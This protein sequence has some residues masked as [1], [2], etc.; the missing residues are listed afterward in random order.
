MN[1]MVPT[2]SLLVGAALAVLGAS[3]SAQVTVK[4]NKHFR[5]AGG[6]KQATLD[7][8]TGTY[9]RGPAVNNRGGTTIADFTNIDAFDG[10]GFGWLVTETGGGVCKW[11]SSGS[12]GTQP[13]QTP[14]N[15]SDMVSDVVFFY[16][17]TALDTLSGGIG[18]SASLE[19]YEGYTVTG[20]RPTTFVVSIGMSQMPANTVDGDPTVITGAGCW[21]LRI[22]FQPMIT[23]FQDQTF[24]GYSWQ[25]D[26][27]GTVSGLA[28]T[29]PFLS[30]IVS[31]SGLNI[32]TKG[33]AG[34]IGGPI[35]AGEDGQG[36]IDVI[37]QFCTAP[38]TAAS[39]SFGTTATPWAPTTRVSVNMRI[40]EAIDAATTNLNYNAT[41]TPNGDTLS[42]NKAT[43]GA[44]WTLTITRSPVTV[45]GAFVV[46]VKRGRFPG[47]GGNPTPPVTG[48]VL[49]AGAPLTSLPSTPHNGTTGSV[50]Q[51][52]PLNFNFCGLHFAAQARTTGG[53]IK[54]SSG[55]EGT[56][57]TF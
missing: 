40:N 41:L 15:N 32:L 29:F 20:G 25:F 44:R 30:C 55:V 2:K 33:T 42:A 5:R 17:S 23:T 9:T 16:C 22:E 11:F 51:D 46:N 36:M 54:L 48:R 27:E 56:V 18:G 1:M 57:G 3:A 14:A 8:G 4:T 34:G 38:V 21:G 39:F 49:I 45:A 7:L 35:G 24:H 28:K 26:D 6:A 19:F 53:G 10:A 37:D 13:G 47:N 31:C 52:V 12:K 50:G 43:V